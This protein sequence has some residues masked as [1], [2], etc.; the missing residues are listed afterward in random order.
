MQKDSLKRSRQ[1]GD[2][3]QWLMP[4]LPA[5]WF[6]VAAAGVAG[7]SDARVKI[8]MVADVVCPYCYIGLVRLRKALAATTH[9]TNVE[10]RYTPFIL[11]R[12]LPKEGVPKHEV[13]RQQFGDD[14][15]GERVLAQVVATAAED[16]LLF[17]LT[18]QRAGNSEDAHRLLLWSGAQTL[19]LMENM[20][21]IYNEEQGWLGDHDVLLRAVGRTSG[22]DVDEAA[23]VLADPSA[24]A[25]EHVGTT[26][27]IS[28]KGVLPTM[29][30]QIAHDRLESGLMRSQSLGVT[31]VPTFF[32]NGQLL[33]S[34]ALSEAALR[35][36]VDQICSTT[37][38]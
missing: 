22:L 12:H 36:V 33:G 28:G 5:P 15:R 3:E 31:G 34:G 10:V 9:A 27:N 25:R 21:K 19:T 38:S 11:R 26:S 20:E 13:F 18:A 14:T 16:G 6:S 23:K 24:Y 7:V 8:E 32:V 35:T 29:A 17:N 30:V 4:I 1:I 37:A 2:D